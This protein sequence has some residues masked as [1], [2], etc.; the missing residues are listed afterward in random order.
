MHRVGR[1]SLVVFKQLK[2]PVYSRRRTLS[3]MTESQNNLFEYTSG[4]W[5]QVHVHHRQCIHL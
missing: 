3:T 1:A 2:A 4:R 5:V